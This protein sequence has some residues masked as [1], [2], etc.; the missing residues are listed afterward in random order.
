MT[1]AIAIGLALMLVVL[2]V[3]ARAAGRRRRRALR[4][5]ELTPDLRELPGNGLPRPGEDW[6]SEA[7][8]W[9]DPRFY[10]RTRRRGA[11]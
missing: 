1:L 6:R 2:L 9:S 8:A 11:R 7:P 5:R 4:L 3:Y 10:G